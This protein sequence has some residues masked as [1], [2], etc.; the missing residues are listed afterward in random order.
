[1]TFEVDWIRR[2]PREVE[3]NEEDDINLLG[4]NDTK[5]N[6]HDSS[7]NHSNNEFE[8]SDGDG[9]KGDAG[10]AELEVGEQDGDLDVNMEA[11]NKDRE[12]GID[13]NIVDSDDKDGESLVNEHEKYWETVYESDSDG[14]DSFAEDQD[15]TDMAIIV[16]IRSLNLNALSLGQLQQ[17]QRLFDMK[18]PIRALKELSIMNPNWNSDRK[19]EFVLKISAYE[20]SEDYLDEAHEMLNSICLFTRS[21]ITKRKEDEKNTGTIEDS[22]QSNNVTTFLNS[23]V[24]SSSSE[25]V[26]DG[27]RSSRE[28]KRN[29]SDENEG[30]VAPL[31]TANS[32]N[33]TITAT[34]PF[35]INSLLRW[36]LNNLA[37]IKEKLL[38]NPKS[39]F[40]EE[41]QIPIGQ[42]C[43]DG[44]VLL[45]IGGVVDL[46][47]AD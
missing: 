34:T 2:I 28:R 24:S 37:D 5:F 19:N 35:Q 41:D 29:Q 10:S 43:K 22:E 26:F 44:V 39:P 6:N 13:E 40:T 20:D 25:A 12:S 8:S 14:D 47:I 1:M 30:I 9:S 27:A 21:L 16:A 46:R 32:S 33:L 38:A 18:G 36:I 15:E 45:F 17:F 11:E 3:S 31:T 42:F 23:S 4:D 7:E